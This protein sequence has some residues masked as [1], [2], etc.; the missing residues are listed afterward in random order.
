MI[1]SAVSAF[2]LD[3]GDE[4][5]P[6]S[7]MSHVGSFLWALSILS[8]GGKV[9]VARTT[10][11]YE[12]LPLLRENRP[13]VLA[14]IPAALMALVR[15]HDLL[16]DD[17][18]SLRVCRAG[19]D[20]VSTELLT[21]FATAAGFPINEGYGMTEVGLATLNPPSGPNK[22]GSISPPM[23]GFGI[24]LRDDAGNQVGPGS[25][26][27][28]FIRSRSR[29]AGYWNAE[30]A[31]NQVVSGDGWIR[32]TWRT[33]TNR[34]GQSQANGRGPSPSS[35]PQFGNLAA[36]ATHRSNRGVRQMAEVP[37]KLHF[38]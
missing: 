1:A 38:R 35:R 10:D 4:F 13:T 7:S 12:L 15:D 37:H 34:S 30:T 26:G 17:F 6:G 27:R 8:V 31:T 5:L 19:S 33:P 24:A 21:E 3:A 14:M 9:V 29:M 2:E 11:A 20:K 23:S 18:A 25:V 16:P 32:V 28:I 22:Q 36:A